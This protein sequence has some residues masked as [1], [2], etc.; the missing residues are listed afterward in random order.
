MTV[1]RLYL[2]KLSQ[3]QKGGKL[4]PS[5]KTCALTEQER[6]YIFENVK[7]SESK[8]SADAFLMDI[9]GETVP[10]YVHIL[11]R[12]KSIDKSFLL[13]FHRYTRIERRIEIVGLLQTDGL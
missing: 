12:S 4:S 11:I 3:S 8:V 13:H 6:E 1:L 2:R 7:R 9:H 10:I 5:C